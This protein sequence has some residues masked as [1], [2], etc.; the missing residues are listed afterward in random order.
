VT[1]AAAAGATERICLF[2]DMLLGP[3]R[4]P[5]LL[6]KQAATLDQV[7]G[8]RLVLGAGVGSRRDDFTATGMRFEDRGRRWDQALELMHAAWRGEPVAESSRPICPRPTNGTSVPMMF[9]GGGDKAMPRVARYGIGYTMGGG[10]P[11]GTA[12]MMQRVDAAW[13]AAG[14][15]GKPLYQALAY[16]VFGDEAHVEAEGNI[17]DYY[18]DWG[19]RVWFGALKDPA[20]ARE[21]LAAF[22]ATGCDEVL[23]FAAAPRLDQVERLAEAVLQAPAGIGRRPWRGRRRATRI[24]RTVSWRVTDLL[25]GV[26]RPPVA[27]RSRSRRRRR[28]GAD[29]RRGQ[30]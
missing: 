29:V 23:L 10:D 16:F 2:T 25:A 22:E 28:G 30:L 17:R 4:E 18:G 27:P 1:L 26:P 5:V 11:N 13:Q 12:Q 9:G 7:S 14:R 19:C 24:T 3:T 20:A 15:A 6:A 21:R 8:G